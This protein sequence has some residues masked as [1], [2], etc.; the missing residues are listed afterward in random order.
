MKEQCIY[1]G[2]PGTGKSFN[3]SQMLE[4]IPKNKVFRVTIH[5]EY[6][7]TDFVGQIMPV[8]SS[9]GYD[10]KFV[11]GVFT[12]AL[13]EAFSDA[14]Y[15]VYLIIEELSRG[16]VSAIFGDVFQLLDRNDDFVSKYPVF[17]ENIANEIPELADDNIYLPANFNILG[18]ININD[19]GVFPIDTAFKRRFEWKYISSLPVVDKSGIVDCKKNNAC[20]QFFGSD[21]TLKE[22]SWLNFYSSLNEYIVDRVDGLGK[23]ED[24]KIGQFFIDFSQALVDDSNSSVPVT[25]QAAIKLVNDLIKNKLLNYLW[26]DIQE[27]LYDEKTLFNDDV[28]SFEDL[29]FNFEKKKVFSNQFLINFLEKDLFRYSY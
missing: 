27:T 12:M 5:P 11:P 13:K 10:F 25:K 15:E 22:T 9:S 23:R 16:N 4:S 1:Y 8:M 28:T 29:Y 26:N 21:G 14:N 20:I 17:N 24:K 6:S 3:I 18:T 19:Q 7:Y 2:A